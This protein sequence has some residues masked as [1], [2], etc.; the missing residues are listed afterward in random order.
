MSSL[1]LPSLCR[2]I[3]RLLA[4]ALLFAS[5]TALYASSITYQMT[6]TS[7]AYTGSGTLTVAS[8]PSNSGFTDDTVSGQQIQ[9]LTFVV[10]DQTYDFSTDP[11]ASAQ[12][13]NGQISKIN[14]GQ[15][16][17]EGPASYTIAFANGFSLYD[18]DSAQPLATGAYTIAPEFASD[19][20]NRRQAKSTSPTP[21]PRSLLLLSTALFGCGFLILRRKR[22]THS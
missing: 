19:D 4:P 16:A 14:F 3:L 21:E 6:F 13:F 10:G 11:S 20:A 18:R 7:G 12:F 1:T 17:N 8:Q 9:G 22:A 15:V 5:A 2:P